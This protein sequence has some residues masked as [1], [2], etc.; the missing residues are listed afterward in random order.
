MNDIR[1][2]FT[3]SFTVSFT[4]SDELVNEDSVNVSFHFTGTNV[5]TENFF[6]L[7]QKLSVEL[8]S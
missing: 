8:L 1:W 4:K 7:T 5:P 3:L 2:Q 6:R